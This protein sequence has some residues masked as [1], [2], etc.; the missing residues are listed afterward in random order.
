MAA[1]E[2]SCSDFDRCLGWTTASKLTD[3]SAT[4][5]ADPASCLLSEAVRLECRKSCRL[6]GLGAPSTTHHIVTGSPYA[7]LLQI[8]S[9]WPT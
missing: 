6:C 8:W 7:S 1:G 5:A 2:D 4:V 3:C 9:R